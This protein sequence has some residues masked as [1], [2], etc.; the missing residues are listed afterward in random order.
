M[1]FYVLF[2]HN[3]ILLCFIINYRILY[4]I[5]WYMIL[6]IL[7]YPNILYIHNIYIFIWTSKSPPSTPPKKTAKAPCGRFTVHPRRALQLWHRFGEASGFPKKS[8][9]GVES[10]VKTLGFIIYLYTCVYVCNWPLLSDEQMSNR[11]PLSLLNE[12]MSNKVGVEHQPV[13]V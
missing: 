8:P 4:V 7:W 3:I 11:L 12:Q 13:N 9:R 1:L 6:L 10:L 2:Y 5:V